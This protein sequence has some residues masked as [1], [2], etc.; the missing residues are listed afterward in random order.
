MADTPT[1]SPAAEKKSKKK[2]AKKSESSTFSVASFIQET[3]KLDYSQLEIDATLDHG[4]VPV[5]SL[6]LLQSTL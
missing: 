1:P 5:P 6:R 2:G 3:K 4:Q